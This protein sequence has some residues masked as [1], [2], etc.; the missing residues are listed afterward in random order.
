[1]QDM[2]HVAISDR[3][4]SLSIPSQDSTQLCSMH[5]TGDIFDQGNFTI[6]EKVHPGTIFYSVKFGTFRYEVPLSTSRYQRF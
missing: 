6:L 4:I 5:F 2:W 1:M 3:Q